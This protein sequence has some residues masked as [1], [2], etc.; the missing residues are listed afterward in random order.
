[1]SRNYSNTSSKM[2]LR[3]ATQKRITKSGGFSVEN[4]TNVRIYDDDGIDVTPKPLFH[5]DYPVSVEKQ[6]MALDSFALRQESSIIQSMM[7]HSSG[8]RS[9]S[10]LIRSSIFQPSLLAFDDRIESLLSIN[11]VDS[12]GIDGLDRAPS[13]FYLPKSSFSIS[14]I[15][16][17][18][19]SIVLKETET[20]YLFE[21]PQLTADL[22]TSE[23]QAVKEENER[24]EYI[25][26]GAGSN[27]KLADAETQTTKIY[28]KSR[29][30][31]KE[32]P[33][34]VNQGT[35]VNNWVMYDTFNNPELLIEENGKLVERSVASITRLNQNQDRHRLS[36]FS[37]GTNVTNSDDQTEQ[38]YESTS[39]KVAIS[40]ME[41]I[42]VSKLYVTAQKRFKGLIKP[43]PYS[44]DL[45]FTYSLDLLWSHT[46][47]QVDGRAVSCIRWNPVNNNLLAAGY[48]ASAN[49]SDG[50][51]LIW[52]MKNPSRP[53]RIYEFNSPISNID[54]SR[55][56]PNQLAIG[57]YDGVLKIIDVS[58][59][60]LVILRETSQHNPPSFSPYWQVQWWNND[61][62]SELQEQIYT[63]NQD[64]AIFCFQ[65]DE[66]FV[67]KEMMRISRIEG[68]INGVE[69]M[70]CCNLYDI[71]L[72]K[73][74]GALL[75]CRHPTV[76]NIYL[77]AS[78]E[79]CIHQCSTNYVH[80]HVDSYLAHDG[81][82]YSLEYSPFCSKI[83]LT[84]GADWCTR[85]WADGIT[86]PLITMSTRMACVRGAA[87]SP[88]HSTIIATC[89]NNEICIWDIKRR[90][91]RPA[92]V[93]VL[94][95]S[96]QL[97]L[98]EFTK[99]G[100]QLVVADAAGV[101]Y[102]YSLE[103][104]P[105]PPFDQTSVLAKAI[106]NSIVTKPELLKK[107]QKIGDP[108]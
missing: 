96:S 69:R 17:E 86:E 5:E 11:A 70:H 101:I 56:K 12:S 80:H 82:I 99:S 74:P 71:P 100:N 53:D 8:L 7:N 59:R 52:S 93:T 50:I 84:C 1:M 44:L 73:Y 48:E 20:F 55:C 88:I 78:D 107:L 92:S 25:T 58:S 27:R 45:K 108:F 94:P 81:P 83:L 95:S 61:E 51:L 90:I 36:N 97:V 9:S 33:K 18:Q 4:R 26:V 66:D 106:E 104:M 28:K 64:G 77:V 76:N 19:V 85:I 47:S 37:D 2:K 21:M 39:F 102:V 30:T 14:P 49:K 87:W 98:L 42:I 23:G 63:S 29:S 72:S 24:Y 13:P 68:K 60:N 6:E 10:S 79:G 75:L 67:A 40:K 89:V 62:K 43:D 15:H 35:F 54:W 16:P 22:N 65:P 91:Y 31:Y 46:F 103:E 32:R 41:R 105:F 38:L 3:R 34:R 57:F